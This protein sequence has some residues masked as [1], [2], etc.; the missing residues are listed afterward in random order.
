LLV[1]EKVEFMKVISLKFQIPVLVYMN[2]NIKWLAILPKEAF[3][4][5]CID[6]I[7]ISLF[8]ISEINVP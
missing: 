5:E 8:T 1:A 7:L 6:I 3:M 4:K 2:H